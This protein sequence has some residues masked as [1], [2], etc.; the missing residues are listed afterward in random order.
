MVCVLSK[1]KSRTLF[2]IISFLKIF[3]MHQHLAKKPKYTS[4][5]Y[6]QRNIIYC[7]FQWMRLHLCL[8]RYRYILVP[9]TIWFRN[10]GTNFIMV[11]ITTDLPYI[12]DIYIKI[13]YMYIELMY[14]TVEPWYFQFAMNIFYLKVLIDNSVIEYKNMINR[15][16]IMSHYKFSNLGF[17]FNVNLVYHLNYISWFLHIH[18][19]MSHFWQLH[20]FLSE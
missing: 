3:L 20:F 2:I 1:Q 15:Y 18:L 17:V 13:E 11:S 8:N 6:M 4:I 5:I 19:N 9:A 12:L 16:G 7:A 10:I 14:K